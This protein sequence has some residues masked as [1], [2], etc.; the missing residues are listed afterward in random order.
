MP[1]INYQL[2]F[3][4]FWILGCAV[5]F[6][7]L[8]RR[9]VAPLPGLGYTLGFAFLLRL[10]PALSLPRGAEY[11]MWVFRQAGNLLRA[12]GDVY[13]SELAH[14]Y[15]PLQLYWFAAAD[16]LAETSGLFFTAWLKLPSVL[17]DTALVFLVFR[18][19]SL[20][21][22]RDR[23][24][25]AAWL[26]ALN[27]VTVLVSAYQGQFDAIPLFFLLLA[28]YFFVDR[29]R[30]H[31]RLV[32]GLSLGLAVLGKTWPIIFLPLAFLRLRS[33]RA[34]FLYPLVVGSVPLIAILL[35]ALL[36]PG[37]LLPMLRRA[38]SA[39]A[40]SGWWGYSAPLNV[41]VTASG[42]GADLYR[43]LIALGRP[44]GLLAASVT[45]VLTRRRRALHALLLVI[46]VLFAVVPNL[47][48]QGLSWVIPV[49]LILGVSNR[50]GWYVAGVFLHMI[51]SYWGLHLNQTLY[52]LLPR[53]QADTVIQL[54]SLLAW[55]PILLWLAEE[56]S[57][58]SLLPEVFPAPRRHLDVAASR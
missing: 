15:L 20:L 56:I 26:Y 31:R 45:I 17:A 18:A 6:F 48:L 7:W 52:L 53:T 25:H 44:A 54:S 16:W 57:D 35:Y 23:A 1:L 29:A 21:D 47:G 14:P 43:Q 50:L 36:F 42:Q 5:A 4:F 19:V 27:P 38:L 2:A 8:L 34:R 30:P 32:S 3:G 51:V 24:H 28:W 49:A 46:L 41:F 11:E 13:T 12:G 40:V 39:G 33:W 37:S 9:G 22:R 58:R 55:L 10:L